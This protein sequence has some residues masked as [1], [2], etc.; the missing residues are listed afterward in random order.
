MKNALVYATLTVFALSCGT[1]AQT[2]KFHSGSSGANKSSSA[3]HPSKTA[4]DEKK[5]PRSTAPASTNS[6]AGVAKRTELNRLEHQSSQ[7]L[8]AQ[9]KHK[10]APQ[11]GHVQ[12][13][14]SK[15]EGHGSDIKFAY[16]EPRGNGPK[17]TSGNGHK[18]QR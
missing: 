5:M 13:V 18:H 6:K 3:Y 14:H 11:S 17:T 16:R 2:K 15:S 10:T 4:D 12:P 8:Q 9:S 7:H 1:A